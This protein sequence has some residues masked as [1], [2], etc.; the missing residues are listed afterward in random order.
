[1]QLRGL[2]RA[3]GVV[4]MPGVRIKRESVTRPDHFELL[5]EDRAMPGDEIN[6]ARGIRFYV[7]DMAAGIIGDVTLEVEN[8]EFVLRQ[9]EPSTP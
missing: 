3:A 7:D 5:I 8:D 9:T 4:G 1:M 2:T 6:E